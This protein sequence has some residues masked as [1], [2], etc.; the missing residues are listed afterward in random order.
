MPGTL[1]SAASTGVNPSPIGLPCSAKPP[2]GNGLGGDSVR[3]GAARN[4][5]EDEEP[6]SRGLIS[7]PCAVGTTRGRSGSDA[8]GPR[9]YS[10][11][12][13]GASSD[14]S[15]DESMGVG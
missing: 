3:R 6:G 1:P 12:N 9:E 5:E 4:K 10:A 15:G 14:K 2:L 8:W 11:V 13:V 7:R